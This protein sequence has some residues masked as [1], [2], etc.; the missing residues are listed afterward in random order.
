MTPDSANEAIIQQAILLAKSGKKP[1]GRKLLSDV[2]QRE[3]ANARVWYLLSQVVESK[4]Q[5]A[6]C[7]S[8]VLEIDPNNVQAKK[9]LLTFSSPQVSLGKVQI[10]QTTPSKPVQLPNGQTQR[11][12]NDTSATQPIVIGKKCPY[13]AE[14]IKPD[15][16]ICR[17][18]GRTLIS[19]PQ[20]LYRKSA[21][22]KKVSASIIGV[23]LGTFILFCVACGFVG[24]L[25]FGDNKTI[26]NGSS[27]SSYSEEQAIGYVQNWK[28]KA[29]KGLTCKETYDAVIYV[30]RT[31]LGITDARAV[32]SATKLDGQNYLVFVKTK[33]ETGW[34]TW[35][36]KLNIPSMTIS[37][38]DE[39]TL[40]PP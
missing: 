19:K 28:P 11:A 16:V 37:T 20:S 7:L 39:I 33:G 9:K 35:T 30:Y 6:Y 27:K 13:C 22:P 38:T 4:E 2:I 12:N 1:E 31:N 5:V 40:C 34:A 29:N 14:T 8:K 24:M 21:S 18:C 3:P 15:A 32:W 17:Y 36:W 26:N 25:V 10:Q 23:L